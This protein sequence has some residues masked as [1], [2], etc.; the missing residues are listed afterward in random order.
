MPNQLSRRTF[1]KILAAT[2]A[3]AAGCSK[4]SARQLMP[5]V[6]PDENVIPGV[7]SFYA[8]VCRECPAGCGVVARVR[9]GRVIKLEGNPRDPIGAGSLCARGQAALQGVYNPDRLSAP[10]QRGGGGTFSPVDWETA[11]QALAR[12]LRA[13]AASGAERVAFV[14]PSF[15]PTLDHIAERWVQIWG[16]RRRLY[17]EPLDADAARAAGDTCFGRRDLPVFDLGAAR[18]LVSFGADFLE[19]WRSPVELTRQYAAFRAPRRTAGG[20]DMGHST[21]VGPR[22]G[23]TAA[24]CDDWLSCRPGTEA[25]LAFAVLHA[26]VHGA[27]SRTT[28]SD[29][30]AIKRLTRDYAPE[31][32][33]EGSGV[34]AEQIRRLALRFAE[35]DAAV[36]LAGTAD[37]ATHVAALLLNAATGNLGKT[38][39]FLEGAAPP[40]S[41]AA[42]FAGLLDSMRSGAVDVL[43][44]AESNPAFVSPDFAAAMA[45]VPLVVWC[46]G[47]PDE[48]AEKAQL[49]LP[50]HHV[51]ES[52]T[53]FAPRPGVTV[54]GQPVMQPVFP[55]LPLGDI[56]L[57]SVH[58]AEVAGDALPWENTRA[59]VEA[60]WRDLQG[61]L[62]EPGSFDAFWENARRAGGVFREAATATV[63]LR[64]QAPS[65]VPATP[66]QPHGLALV[67]F[68]HIFLSDGRGADKPWLQEIPEPV[69][70]FVWDSWIE[71]HPQTAARL[72]VQTDDLL[73]VRSAGGRLQAPVFVTGH[74]H[75]DVLA[76]PIGQ[77]HTAYGRYAR[78]R[79]ANPWPLLPAGQRTV[80]VE[81]RPTGERRRLVSPLAL[82]DMLGRP[83]VEAISLDGLRGGL[84]PQRQGP[85]VPEPYQIR[86]PH[87]Y[88]KHQWGM[89]IDLNACT[90]CSACVA[91]CYAENN[92]AV[93]GKEE[94]ARGHI[95]SWI[96][97]ERYVPASAEAPPLYIMPMLCQQCDNAPCESVC[98]VYAASHN[99]EGLNAQVY[100]RCIGTR[101]C[102]N[103]CPY[104][105][106]RFNWFKPEWPAP[107]ALQLNPDVTVRGVGVME[108][109]TF[110]IQRIRAAEMDAQANKRALG[111]GEIVPACAQACPAKAISFGDMK[112]PDSAMMRRRAAHE[113]RRY[114]ALE[115]LNTEPAIDYLRQI[116]RQPR[117]A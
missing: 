116:Y 106:R 9:E 46:G 57:A 37:E 28:G 58:A 60:T 43:L 3:A 2:S 104:K 18:V 6:I 17:Y 94:V 115:E 53:D 103:N 59:A 25:A 39:R 38:V 13:A 36:A 97:I 117:E 12:Q 42:E 73:E 31:A 29:L 102:E 70:Q 24:N 27:N 20:V 11:L 62:G 26:V 101:Y 21:F 4:P 111:D 74:V 40:A 5:Y 89:T 75:P 83:I 45:R 50:C 69:T 85:R 41:A 98:P 108:K 64:S 100:N 79:G 65:A 34:S 91:A 35:A 92:L 16:S 8:G 47:V 54:L 81:T 61:Q 49:Q 76:V 51:L 114:R 109:C 72:G 48:T 82:P 55:S 44:V 66:D 1:L 68:P 19:T 84:R 15:G 88:P 86:P 30:E 99:D 63:A 52:W 22:F 113:L 112:N 56:L 105:V 14:G 23:L 93:V 33:A 90:G 87:V 67:A 96:R 7:P 71:I 78:S 77:G 110:C 10:R 80:A 32:V 107:L 95:K